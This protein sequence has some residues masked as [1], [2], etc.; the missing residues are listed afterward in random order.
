L[1]ALHFVR[2]L[3]PP[4]RYP[5]SR[6]AR[7]HFAS[8]LCHEKHTPLDADLISA[9]AWYR[10]ALVPVNASMQPGFVPSASGCQLDAAIPAAALGW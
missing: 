3:T 7:R 6:S 8:W 5:R 2:S 1:V 10:F 9:A 4:A